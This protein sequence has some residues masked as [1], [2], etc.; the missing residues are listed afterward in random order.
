MEER[1][2]KCMSFNCNLKLSYYAFFLPFLYIAIRFFHEK[3]FH[4]CDDEQTLKILKF[5]LP[6]LFYL[7]LPKIFSIIF[8]VIV[9]SNTKRESNPSNENLVIRNYH[10]TVEK[11]NKKKFFFLIYIISLLEAL[12]ED[13]Y[14][15]QYYYQIYFYEPI[16]DK[17]IKG[18]LIEEK[19]CTIIF[20]PIFAYLILHT[21][22]HRHHYL[23]L[24]FGYFGS[25]I[26]NSIRFFLDFSYIKDYPYHLFNMFLSLINSL[27]LILIKYLMINYVFLSPYIFLLYDG[28]FNIINS[29][30]LILL[31][32][33]II[34]NL[35]DQNLHMDISKENDNYFSNNFSQIINILVGKNSDFY[36]YFFLSFI[37]S[38]FYYAIYTLVLYNNSPFLI[39]LIEAFLPLDSDIIE[40]MLDTDQDYILNNKGKRLERFAFQTIG[41]LFLFFGALILNEIIIFNCWGL[42]KYTFKKI[43]I[44]AESDVNHISND[45]SLLELYDISNTEEL[46]D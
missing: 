36:K 9:K 5:N 25:I 43:N 15:A 21:E 13:L 24:L 11:G 40:I 14:S 38:F 22:I 39:I 4:L 2:S 45:N 18:W 31:Q 12:H 34:I 41:Y 16:E 35:P 26:F 32:Y 44:R 27:S 6:Y 19:S 23:A 10:I 3:E 46:E 37:F 42:N 30:L 29:I 7:F 17:Y 33:I 8:I 1:K 28:I 20:V